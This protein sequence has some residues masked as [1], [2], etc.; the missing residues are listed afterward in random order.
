VL[1]AANVD[2]AYRG[3]R[4]VHTGMPKAAGIDGVLP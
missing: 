3:G 4:C 2:L 1:S